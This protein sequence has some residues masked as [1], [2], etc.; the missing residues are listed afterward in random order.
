MNNLKNYS[1]LLL[2]GLLLSCFVTPCWSE[3]KYYEW[4]DDNGVRHMEQTCTVECAKKPRVQRDNKGRIIKTETILTPE[5]RRTQE[6]AKA[7]KLKD[8][9]ALK[10]RKLHDQSLISTYSNEKEIELARN[11]NLQQI[12]TRIT[13]INSQINIVETNLANLKKEAAGYKAGGKTIPQSLQDDLKLSQGRQSKLLED[14]DKSKADKAVI[15][16]RFDADKARYKELT[17]K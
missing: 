1:S 6:E 13:S 11:R 2:F 10:E 7:Q 16:A 14:L 12:E 3:T 5:E 4:V 15:D 9:I 8:E 17:G